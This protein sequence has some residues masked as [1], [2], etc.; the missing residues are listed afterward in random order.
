VIYVQSICL[1]V[2]LLSAVADVGA[3]EQRLDLYTRDG[4]RQGYAT[5]DRDTG[6]VDV[7]DKDGRRTGYG[8]TRD[9]RLELF[10]TIGR[11]QETIIRRDRRSDDHRP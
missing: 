8:L 5:V 11:R 10:D 1:G 2:I 3:E 6:R 9:D 7:Y 4:Q